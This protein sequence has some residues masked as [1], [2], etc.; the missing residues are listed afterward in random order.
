[1]AG[2]LSLASGTFGDNVASKSEA[3]I[4]ELDSLK[5]DV[6]SDGSF[7]FQYYPETISDTKQVNYQ[8]RDM[9]G[10]SLPIY[11]WIN[12]GE[13]AISFTAVFATDV[14]IAEAPGA[15]NGK[16][17][18]PTAENTQKRLEYVGQKE[19]NVD[20][21]GA[22]LRLRNMVLP[23]YTGGDSIKTQA[24]RKLLLYLENTGIGLM[25]GLGGDTLAD[26]KAET[27]KRPSNTV[28]CIMTQCDITW[29]SFFPNGLPRIVTVQLTFAEI[30]QRGGRVI[31]P[32]RVGEQGVFV[33]YTLGI[34]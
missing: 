25:G 19:R 15:D 22:I 18:S 29:E 33:P 31:F 17:L 2:L 4:I 7:K 6:P 12:S 26:G 3:A 32:G 34:R 14:N 21:R 30:A 10:G 24:P 5:G 20:I 16:V 13:R 27:T 8:R 23:V 9:P 11:Q 28:L 1:M